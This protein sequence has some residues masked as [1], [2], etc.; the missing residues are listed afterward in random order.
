MGNWRLIRAQCATHTGDFGFTNL[1]VS[2]LN[3][4]IQLD[5]HDTDT[6]VISLDVAGATV[7]RNALTE[8]LG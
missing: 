5:P 1:V 7:L 8:W 6:C 4:T 3:G 2:K